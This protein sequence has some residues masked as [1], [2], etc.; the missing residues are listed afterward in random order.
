MYISKENERLYLA[1]W[2]YNAARI[3][4]ELARI[5]INHGGRVKPL[6]NAIISN[7]TADSARR[8]YKEK[9]ER[10]TELEKTSHNESRVS[11]IKEYSKKLEALEKVNN[12]PVMVTH[13]DYINFVYDDFYYCYQVNDNPFFDFCY[14][15][16]P[17]KNGRYS[18]DTYSIEDKKEWLFDCFFRCDCSFVDV[19]KAANFIFDMLVQ[20]KPSQIHIESK[21]QRVANLYDGG[22]HYE[23][24]RTPERF[25]KIDF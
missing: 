6:K 18:R 24:V 4:T 11:A 21:K 25:I 1:T 12:D 5:V 7:R 20:A 19:V 10:F 13:T 14:H 3:L 8:E 17:V 22:Y 2:E 15:K 9:I 23:T 16:T